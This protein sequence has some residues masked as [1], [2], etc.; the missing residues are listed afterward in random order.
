M[1]L[2]FALYKD[3]Q[4]VGE[5]NYADLVRIKNRHARVELSS[6]SPQVAGDSI[7]RIGPAAF[8]V[9]LHLD[10]DLSSEEVADAWEYV[11]RRFGIHLGEVSLILQARE[12]LDYFGFGYLPVV[13]T[14]VLPARLS[15][16]IQECQDI[17]GFE[18]HTRS[19]LR[20]L[21]G[22][23]RKLPQV[24]QSCNLLV[25]F[26]SQLARTASSLECEL[27]LAS[28]LRRLGYGIDLM[29]E[30][31]QAGVD[32]LV[33]G[34]RTE[35]KHICDLLTQHDLEYQKA[36][37]KGVQADPAPLTIPGIVADLCM[38]IAYRGY[39][40]RVLKK[41]ADISIFDVSRTLSGSALIAHKYLT[42]NDQLSLS[43]QLE[44]CRELVDTG[45]KALL[46]YASAG[47]AEV[48]LAIPLD[49]ALT[50][51]ASAFKPLAR[52]KPIYARIKLISELF[53]R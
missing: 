3:H 30:A 51:R 52:L 47:D 50:F 33:E 45:K 13:P 49:I 40:D 1:M 29:P 8:D 10:S 25:E 18:R 39:L 15:F 48:A 41:R 42:R 36:V 9:R 35:I 38:L 32:M 31:K 21:R 14:Q 34:A 44:R 6:Y 5:L 22:T 12:I 46:L 53:G 16:L 27:H 2:G 28:R 19:Y 20:Q 24:F 23:R 37:W 26:S 43:A 4:L 17:R 7:L 11:E